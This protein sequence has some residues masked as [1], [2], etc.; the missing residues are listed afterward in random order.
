MARPKRTPTQVLRTEILRQ[1][2]GGFITQLRLSTGKQQGEV[3]EATRLHQ[4]VLSRIETGKRD[5]KGDIE[6]K[7]IRF[8]EGALEAQGERRSLADELAARRDRVRNEI[9]N[10]TSLDEMKTLYDHYR[11]RGG[12]APFEGLEH[13]GVD[14]SDFGGAADDTAAG[15]RRQVRDSVTQALLDSES[16]DSAERAF[17]LMGLRNL[18]R[19]ASR[20]RAAELDQ[21]ESAAT[22]IL[23]R[24]RTP[25]A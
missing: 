22:D 16:L 13:S 19:S 7:L 23:L 3:A 17:Y 8:Y 1:A 2:D 12:Y 18:V 11:N 21:L 24:A 25:R 5:L 14:D 6:R 4:T 10:A 20:M 15:L 9:S